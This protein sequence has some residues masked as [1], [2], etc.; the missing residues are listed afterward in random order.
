M[1][2]TLY[3]GRSNQLEVLLSK[4]FHLWAP[5]HATTNKM[6]HQGHGEMFF[7]TQHPLFIVEWSVI[8]I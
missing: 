5:F 6:G 8:W 1:Q 3:M 4:P 7:R 2:V